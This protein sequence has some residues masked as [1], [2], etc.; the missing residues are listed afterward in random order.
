M[1]KYR[2]EVMEAGVQ[3]VEQYDM[4]IGSNGAYTQAKSRVEHLRGLAIDM[5]VPEPWKETPR[6][7]RR[8]EGH[9][10]QGNLYSVQIF[11]QR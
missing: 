5:R 2:V 6:F 8:W 1:A 11:D 7:T 3:G 9:D 10:Q 4:Q